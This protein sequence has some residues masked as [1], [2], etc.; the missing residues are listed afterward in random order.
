MAAW[1]RLMQLIFSVVLVAHFIACAWHKIALTE[2]NNGVHI[3][4]IWIGDDIHK[5]LQSR[6]VMSLYWAIIT[7]TTIGYGDISPVN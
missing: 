1:S 7:M 4:D 5:D 3:E 6:Y 2:Y